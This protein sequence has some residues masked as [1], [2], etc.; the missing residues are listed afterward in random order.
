MK[1]S[2][3]IAA[4]VVIVSG[5]A[6]CG[7]SEAVKEVEALA[8]EMCACKDIKCAAEVTGKASELMKK[9][10]GESGGESTI[11]AIEAAGERMRGCAQ[12]IGK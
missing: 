5:A 7:K 6:A 9:H 8:D 3:M 4:L 12:K 1:R 10:A 11:K 2:G